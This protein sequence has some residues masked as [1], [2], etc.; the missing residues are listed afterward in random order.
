MTIFNGV[1]RWS[2]TKQ[3]GRDPIAWSPGAYDVKIYQRKASSEKV[4]L[5]KPVVC[6][7]GKTGEGHSISAKPEKFAKQLCEE[8]SLDMERVIW[9]EDLLT[10]G[11]RYEIITFHKP[12]KVGDTVFYRTDKRKA[13]QKE[14]AELN[15]EIAHLGNPRQLTD[16]FNRQKLK[17][18]A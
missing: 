8:F 15:K 18:N 16:D 11:S 9:V 6:V 13:T 4:E 2:G 10:D 3:G 5:L 12:V 14:S 7:Y 17:S 1:Y